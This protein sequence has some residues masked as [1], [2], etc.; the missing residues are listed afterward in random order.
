NYCGC[1]VDKF[2]F[3]SG[4]SYN[5]IWV[6]IVVI[7]DTSEALG[8]D[9]LE[10]AETLI[11]SFISDGFDDFL[12]TNT[13][14]PF[15]TRVGVIS[16][17]DRA[18]VVYNLNMTKADSMQEKVSI[19]KGV[20]EINVVDAFEA[21]LIMLNYG[22]NGKPERGNAHQ[23]V[24]YITDSDSK[25]NL[26]SL[27]EFKA[28]KG[29]V[30]VNNFLQEGEVERPALKD[31]ASNG[32]YYLNSDYMQGLQAFCKANC[33]CKSNKDAFNGADPT[34]KASGGCYH[35]TSAGVPFNKAKSACSNEG[36]ILA[37]NH[38]DAKGCFLQQLMTKASAKSDYFWF[39]YEKSET[40]V[41]SWEDQSTDPYTNWDVNEPSSAPIAKCTYVDRT[42]SNLTWNAGNCQLGFPYVCEF[43]PCS[44][45]FKGC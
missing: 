29:V 40:G 30:I 5:D 37:T 9:A 22:L 2:G 45:G 1:G 28:S 44:A 20:K 15:Y 36:G 25:T 21:A 34:I 33:F 13:N 26:Q 3:P 8:E 41:W 38:D 7:L 14:A 19:K 6:D 18:E 24:Y 43:R 11:E 10:D 16:M 35:P 39:G 32:Y 4:W 12:V 42:T 31:L 23:V 27:D 17:S